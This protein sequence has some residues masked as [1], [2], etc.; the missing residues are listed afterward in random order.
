MSNQQPENLV[1]VNDGSIQYVP[2][3]IANIN[4]DE[5]VH[6]LGHVEGTVCAIYGILPSVHYRG[7][8]LISTTA[9]TNARSTNQMCLIYLINH[10]NWEEGG[11]YIHVHIP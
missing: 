5:I 2:D 3:D 4:V 9:T 10:D 6:K 1:A 11:V 8:D 7:S